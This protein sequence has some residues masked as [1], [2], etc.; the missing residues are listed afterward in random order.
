MSDIETFE[1]SLKAFK[2]LPSSDRVKILE[3]INVLLSETSL[4]EEF[5]QGTLEATGHLDI[6]KGCY[7]RL[8]LLVKSMS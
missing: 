3:A 6:A 1:P 7:E 5:I 4:S 8:L 2:G